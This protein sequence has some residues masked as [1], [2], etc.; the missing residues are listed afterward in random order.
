MA[1]SNKQLTEIMLKAFKGKSQKRVIRKQA[2]LME[3]DE[4]CKG[5]T[6]LLHQ[7]KKEAQNPKP[8]ECQFLSNQAAGDIEKDLKLLRKVWNELNKLSKIKISDKELK[9][10]KL[11]QA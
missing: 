4:I 10:L 11:K 1:Q 8:Y 2:L 9:V 3:I 6:E 7:R 5:L